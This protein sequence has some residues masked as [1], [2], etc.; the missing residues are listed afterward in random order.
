VIG[1]SL[2]GPC[3]NGYHVGSWDKSLSISSGC[4]MLSS[5]SVKGL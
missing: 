5:S 2:Y 4:E 3:A 1:Q